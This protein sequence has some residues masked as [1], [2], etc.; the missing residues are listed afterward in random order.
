MKGVTILEKKKAAV[1]Y[2]NNDVRL[3]TTK[4]PSLDEGELLLKTAACGLCGGET[5]EWY[6]KPRAPKVLGHELTGTFV[7]LGGRLIT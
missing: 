7:D 5:M 4:V 6:L 3:M 2:S 1:D